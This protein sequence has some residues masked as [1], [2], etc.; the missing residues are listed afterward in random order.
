MK[1]RLLTY[2][3][4][5]VYLGRNSGKVYSQGRVK[6]KQSAEQNLEAENIYE[7]QDKT[8][9]LSQFSLHLR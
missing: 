3:F 7:A 4:G 8:G 6:K 5:E 2:S 9:D 1:V